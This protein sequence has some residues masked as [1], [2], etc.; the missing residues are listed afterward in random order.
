MFENYSFKIKLKVLL[1]LFVMLS[2]AAYRRSYSSL[3]ESYQEYKTLSEKVLLM[4]SKT[5]NLDKLR[6][7][8]GRLDKIIGKEGVNRE[9]V[10]QGIVGFITEQ[11]STVQ[12]NDLKTI[13][14]FVEENY[15]IYT[16]QLDLLGNYNQLASLSYA[17]EKKFENSKI[18]SMKF[19]VDKKNNKSEVLHL[20]MIFQNYENTK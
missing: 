6:Y 16:Y 14:E 13:H 3:I 19:Y 11:G 4:K 20:K 5:T 15:N 12:I 7:E 10:Q 17:F 1:I 8:I 2:V 18:V 9:K